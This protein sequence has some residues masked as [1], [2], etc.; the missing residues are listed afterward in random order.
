MT[1]SPQFYDP[2]SLMDSPE[3]HP[4][5]RA[6]GILTWSTWDHGV[7]PVEDRV[8]DF[9]DAYPPS[10]PIRRLGSPLGRGPDGNYSVGGREEALARFLSRD[11][12]P[13][14]IHEL[15]ARY[16]LK[17]ADAPPMGANQFAPLEF[18]AVTRQRN[19]RLRVLHG[20]VDIEPADMDAAKAEML[21][22]DE[23]RRAA[24]EIRAARKRMAE[25]LANELA[26]TANGFDESARDK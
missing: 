8:R 19:Y 24:E 13:G 23:K 11:W 14:A 9:V 15:L 5:S 17:L 21:D 26:P 20:S 25:D 4:F 16:G 1:Q 7:R 22:R 3:H 18:R 12:R 10:D 6:M 2:D